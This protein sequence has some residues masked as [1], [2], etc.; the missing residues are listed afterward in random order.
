LARRGSKRQLSGVSATT[1]RN[2]GVLTA[3]SDPKSPEWDVIR[4]LNSDECLAPDPLLKLPPRNYSYIDSNNRLKDPGKYAMHKES[5]PDH[6]K[7]QAHIKNG[8][9]TPANRLYYKDMPP[10]R[11]LPIAGIIREAED[12]RDS[13]V[14]D[15]SA[16]AHDSANVSGYYTG[17]ISSAS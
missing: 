13:I 14:R 8:T 11:C 5:K 12:P 6:P 2:R 15:H 3:W 9:D 1:L 4:V 10:N 7:L 17:Y 16:T